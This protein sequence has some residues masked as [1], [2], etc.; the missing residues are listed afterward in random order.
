MSTKA[1][2]T[3]GGEDSRPANKAQARVRVD[4]AELDRQCAL[5]GWNKQGLADAMGVVRETV[6]TIYRD[7]SA[8]V[9]LF[10]KLT[11]ALEANPP[12]SIAALLMGEPDEGVA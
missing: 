2:N 10:A 3:H 9:L 12:S 6:W 11:N 4:L 7:R 5:R 1:L 8:N